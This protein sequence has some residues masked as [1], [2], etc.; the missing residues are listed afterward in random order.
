V[1]FQNCLE[2]FQQGQVSIVPSSEQC[3]TS[4]VHAVGSECGVQFDDCVIQMWT[5][6][7]GYT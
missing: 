4:G 2:V 3:R 6:E 5:R 1:R 7:K